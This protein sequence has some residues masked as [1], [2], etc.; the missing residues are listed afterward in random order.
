MSDDPNLFDLPM[1][2]YA[3]TS[4]FAGS[5]SSEERAR[6]DDANG[7]T[8]RRQRQVLDHLAR[9]GV[10]G[11]TWKDIASWFDWHHGQASGALSVLHKTDVIARLAE[12]RDRCAI[13][14]LPRFVDGREIDTYK[15]NTTRTKARADLVEILA[16]LERGR[17]HQ[18]T[19]FVEA[20]LQHEY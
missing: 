17:A 3:G 5:T 4:G 6:R 12:R 18:A 11:A 8:T 15:R 14:V 10:Y 9:Q 2:P 7:T 16:M 1:L 19:E 13:Y 20:L